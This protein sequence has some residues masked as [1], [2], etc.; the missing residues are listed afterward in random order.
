MADQNTTLPSG[1]GKEIGTSGTIVYNG[2]ITDEEYNR[3][4]TGIRGNHQYEIMRRSDATI[5]STLQVCK[6]PLLSTVWS[7]K[8]AVLP[9]GTITPEAQEKSDFINRELFERRINWHAFLKQALTMMDFGHSVFEK[10]Y[11]MTEFNGQPRIG[12]KALSSRKQ[13]SIYKWETDDH[14]PGIVQMVV[15]QTYSIPREKLIVFTFDREGDNYAG[16]S[17]L[18]YV[19]KDWDIKDKLTLVNAMALEKLGVGVPIISVRPGMTANAGDEDKAVDALTNMRANNKAYMKIPSAMMVEMLDLK[20][21]T[22]KDV[23]PTL[24]Y[25]DTRIMKSIL[26][27]FLELG[28]ASGSG[29]QAL[30][31]DLSSLFMKSEESVAKD[32]LATVTSDLIQQLCDINYAD[33]SEGYPTLD[34]GQIADDDTSIIATAINSLMQAGAITPTIETEDH[35]RKIFRLPELTEEEKGTWQENQDKRISQSIAEPPA[36]NGPVPT[37]KKLKPDDVNAMVERAREHRAALLASLQYQE[38]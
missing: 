30:S 26:A 13:I 18:R 17:L 9:D 1:T 33:M 38:V 36:N 23:I 22:T 12:I 10:T 19:Y 14:K 28:G 7:V 31:K 2:L 20:G 3:N 37:D 4:L 21:N 11:E 6:L 34:Y 8:P 25:H 29:S 24:Q 15:G 27:G 32:I 16:I 35:L 5:R